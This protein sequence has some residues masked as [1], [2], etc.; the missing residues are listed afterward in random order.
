MKL[1]TQRLL[2]NNDSRATHLEFKSCPRRRYLILKL[3][4][5]DAAK[6]FQTATVVSCRSIMDTAATG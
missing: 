2:R 3:L 6:P 4:V 1:E 5:S